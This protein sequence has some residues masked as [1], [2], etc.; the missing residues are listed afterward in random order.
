MKDEY[1]EQLA[2]ADVEESV[3]FE[4]VENAFKALFGNGFTD[5]FW[6]RLGDLWP[7]NELATDQ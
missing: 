1:T 3:S 4:D 2:P 5:C 6:C 7:P